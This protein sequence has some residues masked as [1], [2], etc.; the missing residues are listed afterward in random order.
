M[1]HDHTD[2]IAVFDIGRTW[3]RFQ[4]FD[5]SLNPVQTE[6]K[7]IGEVVDSEG[8]PCD[9]LPEIEKWITSCL[10]DVLSDSIYRIT[11]VSVAAGDGCLS[12]L[13][14]DL[15]EILKSAHVGIKPRKCHIKNSS[16]VSLI[17]YLKDTDR[18]FILIAT[19]TWCTFM[20]PYDREP[21]TESQLEAG[22]AVSMT[23]AGQQVKSSRFLLG[24]IHDRNVTMLDDHFGVMGELYKTIKI[25]SKKIEKMQANRRGRVFFR[26]GIPEGYADSE[27]D[28]THFLTYADAYHQMMY[29]LVDECMGAYRLII[30]EDNTTEIVYATG[31][32]ARND[33][34]MRILAARIPDK[35]VYASTIDYATALGAAM[36]LYNEA[37][38]T[39][40]PPV[41]LGLKAIIPTD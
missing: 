39:E 9:D 28:L 34:F 25:K 18:P 12:G 14:S 5:R 37:F 23:I 40:L 22:N 1:S 31:G 26:H 13:E 32:F 30:P 24:E 21:L 27:A 7:I 36:E 8:H 3:K 29:D 10:S 33:T 11:A 16:A 19:G 6:E 35:R 20:N 38:D 15:A 4:L 17:P 2:V 41:Y